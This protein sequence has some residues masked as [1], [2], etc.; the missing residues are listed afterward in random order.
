MTQLLDALEICSSKN[1]DGTVIW[2]HGLGADGYD[3][4]PVVQELRLP[5]IR[6]ILPHAPARPI[7]I[8]NG[9]SMPGWYD[10]YG[11]EAGC[12]QDEPG[13]RETQ[14]RIEA[15]IEKEV[16][17][18]ITPDR[19]VL[20]GFSQGGAVALHTALRYPHRLAGVMGLSTYLPLKSSLA[21][22]AQ[23]ANRDLPVFITHG[24]FDNVIALDLAQA[25]ADCLR[26]HGYSV[27]WHE[28]SMAHSVCMEEIA[29][30]RDFLQTVL[31]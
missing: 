10:L 1:P 20:A 15:L 21:G 6:F 23:D 2:L 13:I 7:T 26:Q 8:N 22:E 24:T 28:Y 11:L 5:S 17:R 19:I 31:K 25:S 4:E 3:F 16:A 30:I 12:P 29:D 9:Y 27:T 14:S 18:G